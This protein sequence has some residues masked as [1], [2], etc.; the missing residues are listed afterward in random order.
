MNDRRLTVSIFI[1]FALLLP[2]GALLRSESGIVPTSDHSVISPAPEEATGLDQFLQG[3]HSFTKNRGQFHD[4][5]VLFY[6]SGGGIGSGFRENGLSV[7]VLGPEEGYC[8]QVEFAGGSAPGPTGMVEL[9]HKSNFFIGS[10]PE[11]W[12]VDV[13][14]FESITYPE[15]WNGIDI[16]Y[17]TD[18]GMLKYDIVVRPWADVNDIRFGFEGV[19]PAISDDDLVMETPVGTV[20]D[21]AP[22]SFQNGREVETWWEIDEKGQAAFGIGPYDRSTE[23]VIDP[24]LRFSSYAGGSS[25]DRGRSLVVDSQGYIFITGYTASND[26]PTTTGAFDTGFNGGS[27]GDAF[28]FKVNISGDTLIYSTYLGG[29]QN[30]YG[31]GIDIDSQGN[32]YI[33]GQTF[34]NN[35]PTQNGYDTW[36]AN[37]GDAFVTKVSS[38]GNSLSYSTYLGGWAEDGANDIKVVDRYAYVTGLTAYVNTGWPDQWK[39]PVTSGAYDT[40]HNGGEDVFVTKLSQNG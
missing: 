12:F 16:V 3:A 38:S 37:G 10:D 24:G 19:E 31:Q 27:N 9:E 5:G 25:L 4:E 28:V 7:S 2:G 15:V 13:P 23:L 18:Q 14:N 8:Y 39:Y 32:A 40:V 30:D 26:F 1:V 11:N 35:Y 20:V 17:R 6:T 29:S 36:Y 21:D 33:A 34:S 22:I